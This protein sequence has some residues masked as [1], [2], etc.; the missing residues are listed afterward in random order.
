M[1]RREEMIWKH[2][3]RKEFA[4]R[5]GCGLDT[6]DAHL[7]EIL[8]EVRNYF[9][10]PVRIFSGI[11]CPEYNTKIGG[12]VTSQHLYGKAADLRVDGCHHDSVANYLEG[13][14]PGAYGIGRYNDFTHFDVR[15]WMSRWVKS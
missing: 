11:R 6:V 5:C 1:E 15:P 12:T 2:F 10:A 8:E 4:C 3:E 13:R 14:F 7:L 9:K